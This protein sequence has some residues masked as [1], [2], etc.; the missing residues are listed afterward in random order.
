M[1]EP[2]TFDAYGDTSIRVTP[3]QIA[4]AIAR[5]ADHGKRGRPL[6]VIDYMGK[7][8]SRGRADHE[9]IGETFKSM[10]ESARR[11]GVVFVV[12]RHPSETDR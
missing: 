11:H 9:K 12:S 6:E 5:R 3:A 4:D 2:G 7:L 1:E 8:N 10:K